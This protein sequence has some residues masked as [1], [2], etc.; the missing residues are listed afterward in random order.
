MT[1]TGQ[2]TGRW[3]EPAPAS[4]TRW[5]S[6]AYNPQTQRVL[7]LNQWGREWGSDGGMWLTRAEYARLLTSAS[8]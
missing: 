1:P 8:T 7:L 6:P 2:G 5:F 4:T 3:G